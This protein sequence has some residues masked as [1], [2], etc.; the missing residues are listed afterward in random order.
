MVVRPAP[1]HVHPVERAL[2]QVERL[3]VGFQHQF[4]QIVARRQFAESEHRRAGRADHLQRAFLAGKKR[5]PQRLLP[6]DHPLQR[7]FALLGR[8]RSL[9]LRSTRKCGS[10]DPPPGPE[11]FPTIRAAA[12]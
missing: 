6:L 3:P 8:D 7:D 4:F 9:D 1:D 2:Q 10:R 11:S 5:N 12:G